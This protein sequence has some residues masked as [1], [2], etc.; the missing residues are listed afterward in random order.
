MNKVFWENLE[1]WDFFGDG[2]DGKFCHG[3]GIWVFKVFWIV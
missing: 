3:M 1:V 2:R